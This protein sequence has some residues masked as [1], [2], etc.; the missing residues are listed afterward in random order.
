MSREE[1]N[2]LALLA[3]AVAWSFA[4]ALAGSTEALLYL[5]P[6]LLLALPLAFGSYV[7]E[8][9]LS[10]ARSRSVA[11]RRRPADSPALPRPL[12]ALVPRGGRLLAASLAERAPPLAAAA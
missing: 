12:L 2:R 5:A 9:L 3:F 6:A 1:R 10:A 8:E 7:G 4:M 11:P